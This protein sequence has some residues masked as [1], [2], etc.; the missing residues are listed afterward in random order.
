[1]YVLMWWAV[2]NYKL[3]VAQT[4]TRVTVTS[5]HTTTYTYRYVTTV[6]A[7]V[8]TLHL[9]KMGWLHVRK[10]VAPKTGAISLGLQNNNKL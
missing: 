1:M 5:E 2:I 6:T 7:L 4:N 8:R 9:D 3:C 10:L